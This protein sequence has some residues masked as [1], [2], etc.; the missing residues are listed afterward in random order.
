M[1]FRQRCAH[2]N[3]F[4][5]ALIITVLS[6]ITPIDKDMLVLKGFKKG[7]SSTGSGAFRLHVEALK[8]LHFMR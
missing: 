1:C 4:V 7:K 6:I 8:R 2:A 5:L 3:H